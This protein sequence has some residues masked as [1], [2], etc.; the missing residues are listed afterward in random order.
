MD[1]CNMDGVQCGER[2]IIN[3][4]TIMN[5][6]NVFKITCCLHSKTKNS[7][8]QSGCFEIPKKLAIRCLTGYWNGCLGSSPMRRKILSSRM[9]RELWIKQCHLSRKVCILCR[10]LWTI[11]LKTRFLFPQMSFHLVRNIIAWDIKVQLYKKQNETKKLRRL[12]SDMVSL[13][14]AHCGM[15]LSLTFLK[16]C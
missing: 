13:N 10:K 5:E 1:L 14:V 6:K 7:N 3:V 4:R 15:C 8:I 2:S 12:I 9:L 11:M 16:C